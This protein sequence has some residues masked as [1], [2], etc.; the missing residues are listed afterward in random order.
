MAMLFSKS[1]GYAVRGVLYIA[2]MQ[3]EKHYVQVEEIAE[4]LSVPR[5]FVGK[6]LKRLVKE[7][8]ITSSKGPSGGFSIN[9]STLGSPL[10][11]FVDVLDGMSDLKNCVLRMDTCNAENPCPLHYQ[12]E[13]TRIHLQ[14]I[15]METTIRDLL[16]TDKSD[17]IKSIATAIEGPVP[18]AGNIISIHE[19]K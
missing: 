8:I 14:S 17:F 1:F 4:K 11:R 19:S 13:E 3:D 2:L 12:L 18:T 5:H 15:L 6:I 16:R 10:G 9:D 7:G